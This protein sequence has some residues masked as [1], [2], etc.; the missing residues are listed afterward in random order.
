MGVPKGLLEFGGQPLILRIA[1]LVEPLV[2]SVTLVGPSKSYAALGLPVIEDQQFGGPTEDGRTPGPLAGIARALTATQTD[3]NLLL[4]CDLPYLTRE[5]L[6]WLLARAV[7][8]NAEVIMPRTS[9][10]PEPLAAVYRRECAQPI[11]VALQRGVRKVTDATEQFRT[12]F[13][14]EK[15]W[16]HIDPD[17]RMLRN[18]NAPEDYEEARKWLEARSL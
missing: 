18:M 15:E 8:S 17:G 7:V 11:M 3:W 6:D 13:V 2:S 16:R 12:E 1:R 4:A 14:A 10:G 9:G 5:W